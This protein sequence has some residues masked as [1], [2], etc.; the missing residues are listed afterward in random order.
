MG[1]VESQQAHHL[2]D[3][4]CRA[5]LGHRLDRRVEHLNWRLRQPSVVGPEEIGRQSEEL[6]PPSGSIALLTRPVEGERHRSGVRIPSW[7]SDPAHRVPA[8]EHVEEAGKDEESGVREVNMCVAVDGTAGAKQPQ[9]NWS[10]TW[11]QDFRRLVL[12]V[13]AGADLP[14]KVL[15]QLASC[16]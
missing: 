4:G 7:T 1:R 13:A 10:S 6:L 3:I 8:E 16:L 15:D 14:P 9:H 11:P 12:A 5:G 2:L